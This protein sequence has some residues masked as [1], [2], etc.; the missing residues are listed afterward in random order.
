MSKAVLG[1]V[2]LISLAFCTRILYVAVRN[3]RS[4]IG[5]AAAQAYN[6]FKGPFQPEMDNRE[7][8]LIL[9]LKY[10]AFSLV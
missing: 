6:R 2:G 5:G 4:G 10:V 3:Q 8:E 1:G 9:N 7:A